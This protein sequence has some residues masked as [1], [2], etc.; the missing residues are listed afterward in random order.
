M[1][2]GSRGAWRATQICEGKASDFLAGNGVH[3]SS[4][5]QGWSKKSTRWVFVIVLSTNMSSMRG[6][7]KHEMCLKYESKHETISNVKAIQNA[8]R[9]IGIRF[10]MASLLKK[11]SKHRCQNKAGATMGEQGDGLCGSCL[12]GRHQFQRWTRNQVTRNV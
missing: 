4:G 7:E 2:W 11:L 9:V 10:F 3:G 1:V 5:N 12:P 6:S 8:V